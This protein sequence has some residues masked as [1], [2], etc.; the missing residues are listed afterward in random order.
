MC[1]C[2][3][4][5]FAGGGHLHSNAGGS[6]L[7]LSLLLADPEK[8]LHPRACHLLQH[9]VHQVSQEDRLLHRFVSTYQLTRSTPYK[10]KLIY[11]ATNDI[12]CNHS[13]PHSRINTNIDITHLSLTFSA[14]DAPSTHWKQTVF[15]LEDYLTVRRGEEILGSIAV[16]PN[17]NNEV[18]QWQREKK[19]REREW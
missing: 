16:K 4:L 1:L 14:P 8:W 3:G 11:N 9:R 15:Y 17:E 2:V 19:Q 6:D 13:C 12:K 7:H 18:S 5:C 10:L